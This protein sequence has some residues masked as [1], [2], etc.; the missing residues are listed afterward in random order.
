MNVV[1]SA[2][3]GGG[4]TVCMEL[5]I[6][7]LLS[8]HVDAST[9]HF[10][11]RPG[12]LKVVYLAPA[13]ALVQEKVQEW[14]A[15]FGGA[16]G[17]AVK[18]VTGDTD[19]EDLAGMDATDIICTTP[20]KFDS[21]T[22]RQRDRGGMRYFNEIAL[23][24]ID[25]VH[26]LTE[27]RG[28]SLEAGAVSRIKL[29]S[30][31]TE[32]RGVSALGGG[33][34]RWTRIAPA[35]RCPAA[36][37]CLPPDGERRH[38]PRRTWSPAIPEL[39]HPVVVCASLQQPIASVRFVAVSATVPNVRDLAEWL[40]VPAPGV[41]VFGEETRPVPLQTVVRGYPKTTN[42]F[43]FDRRLSDNLYAVLA[44]FSRG[45]PA[46]VFCP[47]RAG[48]SAAAALVAREAAR[49]AGGAR[50]SELLRDPAHHARLAQAAAGLG[51]AQLRECVAAGVG[52]HH[53]AMQPEDRAAVEALFRAADLLVL[54]TTSTLAVGVNLPAFLVVIKG[55]RRYAGAEAADP[56]GY[57]EYERSTC[58]QM[59]GRAGRPQF[60][61]QG[62]AVIMTER[63]VRGAR[64]LE[65]EPPAG[66][67]ATLRPA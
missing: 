28:P 29:V 39:T 33:G 18:E 46:L 65:L 4:K 55:T 25:E 64:C 3:T 34:A 54:C 40:G 62:V 60:D 42:D 59:V 49:R 48:T 11:H 52:F 45:R 21:L 27:D 24:L 7:R 35:T 13:K 22:R 41:L 5:A 9:G 38:P 19:R 26:L 1:L 16:L 30:C 14:T 57:Q 43:L 36:P 31:M 61:T 51:D 10:R 47:S 6:L 58:L 67:S 17:L 2:P 53:A 63:Q 37:P 20:E 23:V 32:M 8:R 44:E 12:L 56:S 15:R 66:G 50:P